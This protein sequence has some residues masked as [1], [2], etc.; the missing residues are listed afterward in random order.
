MDKLI[1]NNL[2][3]YIYI[4]GV[5]VCV[6][7]SLMISE[8]TGPII[9]KF[10]MW[11]PLAPTQVFF[12]AARPPGNLGRAAGASGISLKLQDKSF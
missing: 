9:L 7:L 2:Y 1:L 5:C 3:I 11:A 6:C 4:S 10:G 8:T 12:P